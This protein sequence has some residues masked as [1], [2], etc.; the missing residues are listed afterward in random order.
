M[1]LIGLNTWNDSTC[2][3]SSRLHFPFQH[4]VT[5]HFLL[6]THLGFTEH[7]SK[8]D[9][10]QFMDMFFVNIKCMKCLCLFQIYKLK[11]LVIEYYFV[12]PARLKNGF[13][14]FFFWVPNDSRSRTCFKQNGFFFNNLRVIRVFPSE[15]NDTIYHDVLIKNSMTGKMST[16]LSPFKSQLSSRF[17]SLH[18]RFQVLL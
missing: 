12:L 2:H 1:V 13:N 4:D 18:K 8:F 6:A 7:F 14:R 10:S 9:V 5:F 17:K 3:Y 11:Q 16:L 15:V